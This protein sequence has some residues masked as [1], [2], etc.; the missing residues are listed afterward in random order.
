MYFG[1]LF[2]LLPYH[3]P[4][5]GMMSARKDVAL[6][7]AVCDSCRALVVGVLVIAAQP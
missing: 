7:I 3:N 6:S 1:I 5:C 2:V 4:C